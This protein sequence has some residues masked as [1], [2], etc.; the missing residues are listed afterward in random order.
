MHE[1]SF[2]GNEAVIRIIRDKHFHNSF[3]VLLELNKD[4]PFTAR[5]ILIRAQPIY[6]RQTALWAK[7][8]QNSLL[9]NIRVWNTTHTEHQINKVTVIRQ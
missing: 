2:H 5:E 8:H 1:K 6:R 7:T 4:F 9:E 3:T